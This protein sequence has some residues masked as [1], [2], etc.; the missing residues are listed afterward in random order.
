M[1]E[2]LYEHL[3]DM[4]EGNFTVYAEVLTLSG[5]K[6]LSKEGGLPVSHNV[7]SDPMTALLRILGTELGISF[8]EIIKIETSNSPDEY[9]AKFFVTISSD[10][11]KLSSKY[12]F[13]ENHR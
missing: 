13:S 3:H 6:I 8:Y 10:D 2:N 4:P 1:F 9:S 11:L 7:N 12:H 5:K